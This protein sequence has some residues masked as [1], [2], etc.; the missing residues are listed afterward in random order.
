MRIALLGYGKMGKEIEAIATARGH[1]I[2]AKLDSENDWVKSAED[3]N[4]ADVAIE[5]SIPNSVVNNIFKCFDGNL[6]VVVGTTGW[7]EQ[8]D[9]VK[10][11]C[12]EHDKTLFYASNFS[13]GVNLF[14]ELNRKLAK[15]MNDHEEYEVRIEETHHIH[16]VD[17]PSGSAI[18]L[19]EG[20]LADL[21]RK[22]IWINQEPQKDYQLQV[23]SNR[24]AET[25]GTHSVVY[26][27]DIDEIE[28]KHVAHDRKGFA[29]GAV[30]AAEW[31]KGRKGM[32]TMNDLLKDVNFAGFW[33]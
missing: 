33:Q 15:M 8:L 18:H 7:A 11:V 19:A 12:M 6:P 9:H 25:P 5:F 29:Q 14:F 31:L 13:I 10:Q 1:E 16:K 23:K 20:I 28:I 27:S 26:A 3:L 32:Y 4:S 17:S 24:I 2:V 30:L 21:D 22:D